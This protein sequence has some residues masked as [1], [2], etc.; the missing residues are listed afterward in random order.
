MKKELEPGG[1]EPQPPEQEV[2]ALTVMPSSRSV[3]LKL[4][5]GQMISFEG[6][7]VHYKVD[8]LRCTEDDSSL[9]T[10]EKPEPDHPSVCGRSKSLRAEALPS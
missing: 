10:N 5:S 9:M 3:Q 8:H 7:K 4:D 2:T 6:K 1:F